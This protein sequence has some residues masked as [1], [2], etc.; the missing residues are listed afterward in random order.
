VRIGEGTLLAEELGMGANAEKSAEFRRP[1]RAVIAGGEDV[2]VVDIGGLTAVSRNGE[3][4]SVTLM[5]D[6]PGSSATPVALTFE[7]GS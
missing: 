7:P 1:V 2:Y 3:L 5:F 4:A 6:S